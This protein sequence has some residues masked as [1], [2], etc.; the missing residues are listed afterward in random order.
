MNFRQILEK[1]LDILT[2][3]LKTERREEVFCGKL[4]RKGWIKKRDSEQHYIWKQEKDAEQN[5]VSCWIKFPDK[6]SVKK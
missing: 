5:V 2:K 3:M 1:Y 6:K 4:V